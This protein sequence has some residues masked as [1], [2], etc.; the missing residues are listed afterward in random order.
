MSAKSKGCTL[1]DNPEKAMIILFPAITLALFL[2]AA[3]LWSLINQFI[4]LP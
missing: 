3:A 1:S 2:V 4:V